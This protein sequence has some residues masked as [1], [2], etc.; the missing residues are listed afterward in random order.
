MEYKIGIIGLGYVGLPLAVAFGQKIETIGYDIN[1]NRIKE[2]SEGF[3]NTLEVESSELETV[4]K[5]LFTSSKDDLRACNT[6]IVTVPTPLDQ[7]KQPDLST[8]KCA[9]ELVGSLLDANDIVIYES[10]VYPGARL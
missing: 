4:S 1:S 8:L 7:F 6:Y 10:T 3:D 5:L 2:L 9:S